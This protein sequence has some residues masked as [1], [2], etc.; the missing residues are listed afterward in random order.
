MARSTAKDIKAY[1][2]EQLESKGADTPAFLAMV[3]EYMD[4]FE[5]KE[6]LR[7]D[8]KKRGVCVYYDNG[9]GQRGAK[10]NDCVDQILKVSKQMTAI[11]ST[12][13]I[14]VEASVDE[15]IEL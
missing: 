9:G 15:E 13:E 12:L 3:D 11:L 10:R 2:I 8:I 7:K 4:L 5:I 14:K 1:L 6:A